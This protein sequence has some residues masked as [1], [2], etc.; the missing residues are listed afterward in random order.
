MAPHAEASPRG[1]TTTA[2]ATL[3]SA[4]DYAGS[5]G[6]KLPLTTQLGELFDDN[7]AAKILR[8][9]VQGLTDNVRTYFN[10]Q[11]LLIRY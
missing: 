1:D 5:V 7:I 4:T 3:K 11:V 6:G 8:T 9:A 10:P 2:S